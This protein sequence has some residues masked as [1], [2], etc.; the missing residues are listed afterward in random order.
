MKRHTKLCTQF[1]CLNGLKQLHSE[2][3]LILLRIW[4]LFLIL[5]CKL[6]SWARF[7]KEP[8]YAAVKVT[9]LTEVVLD[10][11]LFGMTLEY[12]R[13]CTYVIVFV[14]YRCAFAK[15]KSEFFKTIYILN[16]S[17]LPKTKVFSWSQSFSLFGLQ[18]WP[19]EFKSKYSAFGF[20][21]NTSIFCLKLKLQRN[22]ILLGVE[23]MSIKK[24]IIKIFTWSHQKWISKVRIKS[25][26]KIEL[27]QMDNNFFE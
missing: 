22:W 26:N 19:P 8:K 17:G 14:L 3:S 12:H 20:V 16:G 9:P 15:T 10:L 13:Y 27:K 24:V 11:R 25:A 5:P 23:S 6:L 1:K 18:L 2:A 4:A 7:K 21:F